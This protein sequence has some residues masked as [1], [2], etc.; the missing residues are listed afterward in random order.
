MIVFVMLFIYDL[1]LNES[2]L[3]LFVFN[4]MCGFFNAIFS[5]IKNAILIYL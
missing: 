2:V 5:K 3:Y 4:I 1:S